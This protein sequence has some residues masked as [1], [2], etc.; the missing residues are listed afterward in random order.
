MISRL[1]LLA[2]SATD[3]IFNPGIAPLTAFGYAIRRNLP[4]VDVIACCPG[5]GFYR[6]AGSR[7]SAHTQTSPSRSHRNGF[8][9]SSKAPITQ[10]CAPITQTTTSVG[11]FIRQV[12]TGVRVTMLQPAIDAN[13]GKRPRYFQQSQFPLSYSH[14][15]L[16]MSGSSPMSLL[17]NSRFAVAMNRVTC[18]AIPR[19]HRQSVKQGCRFY[20]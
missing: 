18:C 7:E 2:A 17:E 20:S 10:L 6:F 8:Q 13:V 11:D 14:F 4:P 1:E 5:G 9:D 19:A 3:G 16:G 12:P 15:G